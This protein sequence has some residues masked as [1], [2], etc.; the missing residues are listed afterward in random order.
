MGASI[1][2]TLAL[3]V[4]AIVG[5][6]L[7]D[8]SET[9]S[10]SCN[11]N[12]ACALLTLEH[13]RNDFIVRIREN[14][15]SKNLLTDDL[16]Q[17]FDCVISGK[18]FTRELAVI[19][20]GLERIT[21]VVRELKIG[22]E[23]VDLAHDFSWYL[24][25][26]VSGAQTSPLPDLIMRALAKTFN[27]LI[28]SELPATKNFTI[29]QPNGS[30]QYLQAKTVGGAVTFQVSS[31]IGE[32][33]I[34]NQSTEPAIAYK[35]PATRGSTNNAVL[36]INTSTGQ[37]SWAALTSGLGGV[38]GDASAAKTGMIA[39][40]NNNSPRHITTAGGTI[41]ISSGNTA[42]TLGDTSITGNTT[43]AV[44][45]QSDSAAAMA[46]GH[47][48]RGT[49]TTTSFTLD[50]TMSTFNVKKAGVTNFSVGTNG[51]T[52]LGGA[53]SATKLLVQDAAGMPNKVFVV[54]T[55]NL[56]VGVGAAPS[57]S[58]DTLQIA[59]TGTVSSTLS[60]GATT[61]DGKTFYVTGDAGGTSEWIS[62]S[63]ARIKTNINQLD[64]EKM[65][66]A[67][68]QLKPISFQYTKE[69]QQTCR[70][71]AEKQIGFIAQEVEQVI[72]EAITK[73]T[74]AFSA[75]NGTVYS[76]KSAK[77]IP[78]LVCACQVL[79]RQNELLKT[80]QFELE[81]SQLALEVR[82]D[83]LQKILMDKPNN[84]PKKSQSDDSVS[85]D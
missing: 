59:G 29:N 37:A 73:T 70:T 52:T 22:D 81:A 18:P 5:D 8:Q 60:V 42:M 57:G 17:I 19:S 13:K 40:Y 39:V 51:N 3:S 32:V 23:E 11:V 78:A 38:I 64:S 41:V 46:V 61:L 53:N 62:T 63:D 50:G 71:G 24:N 20:A 55:T 10:C 28:L 84:G 30:A 69:W 43:F 47:Y 6:E 16:C 36:T 15:V 80:R 14:L 44:D 65:L 9:L 34:G 68:K 66:Q 72:P 35:L 56:K 31:N 26:E 79:S 48:N 54:D 12:A 58:G 74:S 83:A 25:T 82:L 75:I 21:Q 67:V 76:L 49:G 27:D 45:A 2:L 7:M 4:N 77:L 1:F 33:V 85:N